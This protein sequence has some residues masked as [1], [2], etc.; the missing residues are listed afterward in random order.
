MLSWTG[1]PFTCQPSDVDESPHPEEDPSSYVQR[2]ALDK[3]CA[4]REH[5][6]GNRVILAAD[7][8]VVDGG[9][10]MGKPADALQARSMLQQLRGRTHQ[11]MTAL[12]LYDFASQQTALEVCQADV[13]MRF[14][15]DKEIDIYIESG[16][17]LD[18]AGAYAIQHR[19]FRPVENFRQ[20]F[21]CVMGLPLCH[22]AKGMRRLGFW[23]R[24]D[25][26]AVCQANLEYACPIWAGIY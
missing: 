23:P 22:L 18:K 7:T 13:S 24:V 12:A 8:V 21:A 20:C 17:P 14:Y 19:I 1:W 10:L 2:L 5:A 3:M 26:P 9:E 4:A 25:I 15:S 16:D 11:V 6:P